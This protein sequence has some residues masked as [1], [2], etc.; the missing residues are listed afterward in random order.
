MKSRTH[1]YTARQLRRRRR[2]GNAILAACY[3]G[4][5]AIILPLFLLGL[6][7]VDCRLGGDDRYPRTCAAT[8]AAIGW[9]SAHGIGGR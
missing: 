6:Q 2:I 9:L 7:N 4:P 5:L 1:P 3:V 8:H